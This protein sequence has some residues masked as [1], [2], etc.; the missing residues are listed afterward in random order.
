MN[1]GQIDAIDRHLDR[2]I[3][4]I[5][6]V[7]LTLMILQITIDVLLRSAFSIALPG[8][9]EIVSN[10]Y[11]VGLSFLPIILA[12]RHGRQISANF[13]YGS[14]PSGLQA[15]ARG[16]AKVL[17]AV[18]FAILT[19]RSLLE[20]TSK[21]RIGAYATSGTD[22]IVIWPAYWVLPVTFALLTLAVLMPASTRSQTEQ[23][24]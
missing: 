14:L 24:H 7:L 8:T 6:M 10:Y 16:L 9:V 19:W 11:M 17:S 18:M 3:Y 22:R 20:A 1:R 2:A 13:L 12:Q 21:T 23:K 5:G 15:W 4:A